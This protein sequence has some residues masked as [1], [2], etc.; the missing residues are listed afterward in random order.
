MRSLATTM[1]GTSSTGPDIVSWGAGG[2]ANAV[3]LPYDINNVTSVDPSSSVKLPPATQGI[4]LFVANLGPST[5]MVWT[6]A[7][8]TLNAGVSLL[9]AA[10]KAA[11]FVANKQ[12]AWRALLSA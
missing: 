10:N 6:T 8:D 3:P 1:V 9:I 7:P 2:Q 12:G 11:L 5:I 4:D